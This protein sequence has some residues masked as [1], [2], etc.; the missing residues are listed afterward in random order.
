MSPTTLVVTEKPDAALHVAEALSEKGQAKKFEVEGVPFFEVK[1]AKERIIVC[2]ALGHLYGVDEKAKSVRWRYPVW[3]FVWKPKHLVER[4]QAKQKKWI[5][6]IVKVSKEAETFVNACDYDIEGSLIGYMILKHACNGAD[7]RSRRMKYSTLT[8]KELRE[9]YANLLPELDYSLVNAGMCRHEVDWLYGINLSRALTYSAYRQS[10][11]YSTL[12][13]GRVQGPTLRFIVEREKEIATF[14]PTPYWTIRTVVEVS[15]ERIV[16]DYEVEKFERRDEAQKV[17]A[18]CYGKQ[19]LID[20]VESRRYRLAPPTPF[21][22]SALQSEAYRHFGYT[23]RATLGIAER[24]YLDAL[25][26][27]PRTSSQKLPPTI[28]Y[29]EILTGLSE[30]PSYKQ[31][32]GK[33]LDG[34]ELKPNDGKKTDPAHP[35]I[36]PTG[37]KAKRKLDPREEKL[38]DLVV[39]RFMSTFCE[40]GYKQ[41]DKATVLVSDR[42]FYLRGSRIVEKGW[43][44]FYEPYAKFEEVTLPPVEKGMRALLVEVA[45][46]DKF[47]QPPPRYNPSSLLK[48]M[49]EAEIGTKATRADIVET[50]YR[51]GYVNGERM[52]ATKLGFQITDLLLRFCPKVIDVKFTRELEAMME[53]IEL[54]KERRENVVLQTVDYLR[55]VMEELR[56]KDELIGV[57]LTKTIK[58][59]R[60]AAIT[61]KSP[62]PTCNSTLFVLR[63]RKSGKRFIGCSGKWKNNCS[64]GLPLPQF[65]T[66]TLLE[67]NCSK[68]GF[69]IV[70]VRSKG[71]RP[72]VSCPSCFVNKPKVDRTPKEEPKIEVSGSS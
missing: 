61:L 41:S 66:L 15:G 45:V 51:R 21:D 22:L 70:Q 53:N 13:T 10:K 64:F 9:A 59:M 28:G 38:Y 44:E 63:S 50:L 18:D 30:A 24:L 67:K 68:C 54:G 33:L 7:G 71:R 17:V 4:G 5:E 57:E 48:T 14:I 56:E 34:R 11:R 69:Q 23:P 60:M 31:L 19:G 52:V 6:T 37:I 26:S 8:L 36:Y 29:K 49:E 25:V 2:S 16:A 1:N 27:Y 58:E 55:P 43:I 32:A 3:D 12:S 20:D 72:L 46:Q 39:K 40:P 62:C 65:G 35:A 42:R 47:T